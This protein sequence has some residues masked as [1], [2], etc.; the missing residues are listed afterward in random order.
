MRSRSS[1]SPRLPRRSRWTG[2]RPPTSTTSGS[3]TSTSTTAA[4][5]TTTTT[6]TTL[7][8]RPPVFAAGSALSSAVANDHS[9]TVY[10]GTNQATDPDGNFTGKVSPAGY[11]VQRYN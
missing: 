5:T 7:P 3:S 11:N 1:P 8:N 9:V 4:T 6:T 10:W 2:R